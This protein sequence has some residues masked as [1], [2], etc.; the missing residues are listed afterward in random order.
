[1]LT[2][3]QKKLLVLLDDYGTNDGVSPSYEEMKTLMG[4]K[5]KSGI[6]R[7]ILA[8]EERGFIRR[9]QNR[10]RSIEVLR[11]PSDMGVQNVRAVVDIPVMGRI[12]TTSP[13]VDIMTHTGFVK[14]PATEVNPYDHFAL[15]AAGDSMI[16]VGILDGD[17]VVIKRQ[18][19]ARNGD[20]VVAVI[21][22]EEATLKRYNKVL[23]NVVLA[24][25][26]PAYEDRICAGR[27]VRIIGILSRLARNY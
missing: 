19:T 8:L 6:H 18:D 24:S 13:V 5:S 26:N 11:R 25:A 4:L 12:D 17:T 22:E 21:N 7:L 10:A 3:T 9:L 2:Q 15:K 14:F 1:M 20:I 23:R 27:S 16:N